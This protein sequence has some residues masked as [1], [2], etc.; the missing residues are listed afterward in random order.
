VGALFVIELTFL[1][2]RAKLDSTDVHALI[3]Y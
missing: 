3:A 1:G 2:G